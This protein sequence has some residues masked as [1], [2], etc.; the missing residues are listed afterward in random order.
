MSD[1]TPPH[2]PALQTLKSAGTCAGLGVTLRVR[3]RRHTSWSRVVRWKT[4]PEEP[5][6]PPT[7]MAALRPCVPRG[8]T[9]A[10]NMLGGVCGPRGQL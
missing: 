1:T 9:P 7:T 4:D 3:L 6:R 8:L 2:P 5:D 10:V